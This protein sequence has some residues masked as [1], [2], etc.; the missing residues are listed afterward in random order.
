MSEGKVRQ[1]GPY[2]EANPVIFDILYVCKINLKFKFEY[3]KS[4]TKKRNTETT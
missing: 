1:D 4:M 3:V 2:G